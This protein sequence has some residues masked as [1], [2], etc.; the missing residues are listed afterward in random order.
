MVIF[1]LYFGRN[2]PKNYLGSKTEILYCKT[3]SIF[4]FFFNGAVWLQ[5]MT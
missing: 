2:L 3:L 1:C 4:G 5:I